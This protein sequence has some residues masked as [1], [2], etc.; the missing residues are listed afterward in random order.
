MALS[1]TSNRIVYAGN[2]ST[3]DFSFPYYYMD[4]DH[5]RVVLVLADGTEEVKSE[6]TDYTLTDPSESGGTVS[7]LAAPAA[8]EKLSI[9][10]EVPLTQEFEPVEGGPLPAAELERA[11]DKAV[12]VMQQLQDLVG[13]SLT[14]GPSTGISGLRL[15]TPAAQKILGW[16]GTGDNLVNYMPSDMSLF[17]LSPLGQT[18]CAQVAAAQMRAVMTAAKRT[19]I[20]A[21]VTPG[22]TYDNTDPLNEAF[23]AA[24]AAGPGAVVSLPYGQIRADGQLLCDAEGV[25]VEGAGTSTGNENYGTALDL[26]YSGGHKI[27]LGNGATTRNGVRFTNMHI[28]AGDGGGTYVFE[29]RKVR[30]LLFDNITFGGV[31]GFLKAGRASEATAMLVFANIEGNMKSAGS[32]VHEHFVDCINVPGMLFFSGFG[33]VEGHSTIPAG[34]CCVNFGSTSVAPDGFQI[35]QWTMRLFD[36]ILNFRSGLANGFVLGTICDGFNSF[37][38]YADTDVGAI[39]M[40]NIV[41]A[42]FAGTAAAKLINSVGMA[43]FRTTF[44]AGGIQLGFN[45]TLDSGNEGIWLTGAMDINVRG[46]WIKDA[47]QKANNTYDGLRI[48]AGVTGQVCGNNVISTAANKVRY[49]TIV[50]SAE[51]DLIV[52]DNLSIG[53]ATAGIHNPNRGSAARRI[54]RGNTG[55]GVLGKYVLGNWMLENITAPVADGGFLLPFTGASTSAYNYI[56]IRRGRIVGISASVNAAITGGSLVVKPGINGAPGAGLSVT[57]NS[58][59]QYA[60][61]TYADGLAFNAGDIISV[62]YTTDASFSPGTLDA[63]AFLEVVDD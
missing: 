43:I 59:T 55:Q 31:Y 36:R 50:E 19:V 63:L 11:I 28:W 2:G 27:I 54:V 57:L 62:R 20:E 34:S 13:R 26:R 47:G 56:A 48:G 33:H 21:D 35:G 41:G 61:A 51:N 8:G 39:N 14:L 22:P 44:S 5:V 40:L 58:A 53:H 18:L 17:V 6:T 3:V 24:A 10:R 23:M 42:H 25:T 4:K 12:M 46:N 52:R 29:S 49:G 15:P 38:L 7:M 30:G 9:F 1:T 45:K 37:G 32:P 60:F 16:N